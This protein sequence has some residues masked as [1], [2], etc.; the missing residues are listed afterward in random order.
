MSYQHWGIKVKL[1][2][3]RFTC[4]ALCQIKCDCFPKVISIDDEFDDNVVLD[5]IIEI[6]NS[7]IPVCW[8]YCFDEYP[9]EYLK[10]VPQ[11]VVEKMSYSQEFCKNSFDSD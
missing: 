4:G 2:N 5:T 3:P 11:D 8:N 10:K 9:P 1:G 6:H 7:P